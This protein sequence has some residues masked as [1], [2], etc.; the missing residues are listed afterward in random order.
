MIK[1]KVL[2][3]VTWS[4][5]ERIV[6]FILTTVISIILARLISPEEYG[7][8]ALVTVFINIFT[9]VLMNG[10]GSA[11]VQR[12]QVSQEDYST[13]YIINVIVGVVAY[14]VMCYVAPSIESFYGIQGLCRITRVVSLVIPFAALSSIQF[15]YLQKQMK[16]YKYFIVTFGCSVISGG[17]GIIGAISGLGIWA[18]VVYHVSRQALQTLILLFISGL[19]IKM[20][21]SRSSAKRL[22]PFG[23]KT[24]TTTF[25]GDLETNIRSLIIGKLFS[26]A[27]LAYYNMGVNYPKMIIANISTSLGRVMF[28]MFSEIQD[29]PKQ[30]KAAMRRAVKL[31]L[32]IVTPILI[33]FAGIAKQFFL[34]FYT[35]KWL[36][37]VQYMQILSFAYIT[38]PYENICYYA[39][40]G[41]GR[42]KTIMFD[43]A[44][45]KAFSL[46]MIAIAVFYFKSVQMIAWGVLTTTV[47]AVAIYAYQIRKYFGYTINEQLSDSIGIFAICGVMFAILGIIGSVS[48]D[49]FIIML[50][51]IV[52]GVLFYVFAAWVLKID[53][54]QYLLSLVSGF[55]KRKLKNSTK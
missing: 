36:E 7:T 9:N 53:S 40:M 46:L 1:N 17:I 4:A 32:F 34:V 42:S 14:F 47:F 21:F 44:I 49:Q 52:F 24:M 5:A 15:S 51:Q 2:S 27:D 23:I 29:D 11:L 20:Q 10:L 16:F 54:F 25:I 28:P 19:K 38:R 37:A 45:T 8:I 12:K 41:S 18:L 43:M 22:L 3:G 31:N 33:G 30:F 55:L 50:I 48:I 35:E 26:S 6:S 13:L 39:I